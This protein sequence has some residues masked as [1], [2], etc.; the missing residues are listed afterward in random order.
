[1]SDE[2][3]SEI[4][5]NANRDNLFRQ[6]IVRARSKGTLVQVFANA[7]DMESAYEGYVLDLGDDA[8]QLQ[9]VDEEG[10][11]DG[12]ITMSFREVTEIREHSRLLCRLQVLR[13]ADADV[14]DEIEP[15]DEGEEYTG[16]DLI[17]GRLQMAVAHETLIN[18]RVSSSTDYRFVAGY[19]RSIDRDFV[20]F[21]ALTESGNPDGVATVRLRDI[22]AVFEDDWQIRRAL[23]LYE[24]RRDL[25]GPAEF[26][27][28]QAPGE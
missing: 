8:F 15:G 10:Q 3:L 28:Y 26:D 14:D 11:F 2:I 19:V 4:L 6:I 16:G 18:V 7:H 20:Q 25:Y 13:E 21:N 27:A 12:I 22:S 1:M 24:R 9:E 5:R 17:L 23:K